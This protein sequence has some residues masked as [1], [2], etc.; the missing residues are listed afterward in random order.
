M[1]LTDQ[2]YQDYASAILG[3]NNGQYGVRNGVTGQV[4]GAYD[5]IP[6]TYN[7]LARRYPNANL[8]TSDTRTPEQEDAAMRLLA[9]EEAA[10]LTRNGLPVTPE[11]LAVVHFF[12]VGGGPRVLKAAP[13]TPLSQVFGSS[14]DSIVSAN[15]MI[16]NWTVDSA[17]N[18]GANLAG[19]P[20]AYA[21]TPPAPIGG[22]AAAANQMGQGGQG[23][24][25]N[26]TGL[27]GSPDE[28]VRQ[29][30]QQLQAA[31][32]DPG[33]ID[34]RF[35]PRTEAATR[36]FQ[37]ARGITVDGIVG[38]ETRG[39]MGSGTERPQP[40]LDALARFREARGQ[41]KDW[42][43]A[44]G[45]ALGRT[46]LE[47]NP[48]QTPTPAMRPVNPANAFAGPMPQQRPANPA[49]VTP[50]LPAPQP[51]PMRSTPAT[52]GGYTPPLPPGSSFALPGREAALTA[53][54]S[55]LPPMAY[56]GSALPQTPAAPMDLW[57]TAQGN[58]PGIRPAIP[59]YDFANMTLAELGN[60]IRNGDLNAQQLHD[61][62][63][64]LELRRQ[65]AEIGTIMH[66]A[67]TTPVQETPQF[68]QPTAGM[69]GR[70]LSGNVANLASQL[71][72]ASNPENDNYI[73][74]PFTPVTTPGYQ[75]GNASQLIAQLG[76]APGPMANAAPA[77]AR[78]A[79]LLM[80]PNPNASNPAYQQALIRALGA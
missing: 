23:F 44:L 17:R 68:D 69:R 9:E 58:N 78:M 7:D 38:N 54:A 64:V 52:P 59:A 6:S 48:I 72:G 73:A 30:Q 26:G 10:A 4:V 29:W 33:P 53:P 21:P 3:I 20:M 35:G 13:G 47:G 75:S 61:A 22:A 34:G 65:Q 27:T 24:L 42:R 25:R 66:P 11:N 36:A 77:A 63:Q 1:A 76:G 2:Q 32:F 80:A 28:R 39:A 71:G 56:R 57:Q 16:A 18:W 50:G 55:S 45:Y 67:D 49:N 79:D 8:G 70:Y 37:Q 60:V 40:I 5:I 46:D 51:N 43:T 14:W 41:N 19:A 12:G 62:G 15:P 31:G 74:G